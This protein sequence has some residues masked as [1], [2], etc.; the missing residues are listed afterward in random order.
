MLF[1]VIRSEELY[2]VNWC[3]QIMTGCIKSGDLRILSKALKQSEAGIS[4]LYLKLF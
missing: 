4:Q 1:S 3:L 2:E